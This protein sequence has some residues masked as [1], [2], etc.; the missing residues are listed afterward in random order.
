MKRIILAVLAVLTLLLGA[1]S[2]ASAQTL[3]NAGFAGS[4]PNWLAALARSDAGGAPV[5]LVV[6]GDSISQGLGA[7]VT[8]N[9]YVSQL[10]TTLQSHHLPGG[11]GFQSA[12]QDNSAGTGAYSLTGFGGYVT[13]TGGWNKAMYL[14]GLP[15][16]F[17]LGT[18]G[19]EPHSATWPAV[20]GD[21]LDV[22]YGVNSSEAF[23]VSVDGAAPYVVIA[24]GASC[25]GLSYCNYT[26]PASAGQHS[27]VA[28]NYGTSDFVLLGI[29]GRYGQ[30]V[31]V[32]NMSLYGQTMG[33][34][35]TGFPQQG[36]VTDA[37]Q[38][39]MNPD[40]VIV[41]LGVNDAKTPETDATFT[42]ALT[43][44][45]NAAKAWGP[46]VDVMFVIQAASGYDNT[47]A[48]KYT[49]L[50][51]DMLNFAAAHPGIA[52]D[53]LW[54]LVGRNP[55]Y[56]AEHGLADWVATTDPN[57]SRCNHPGGGL[58]YPNI[59]PNHDGHTWIATPLAQFLG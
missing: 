46:Q 14:S 37:A 39:M 28:S 33:A 20:Q 25:P 51:A 8:S 24:S 22:W 18:T 35:G 2:P 42:A 19:A 59:H 56:Y 58:F 9:G 34:A 57:G 11:T 13:T 15:A 30:G 10:A 4:T 1:P 54:S 31:R 21:N 29:T 44:I 17:A 41:S 55:C 3:P 45:Y 7:G 47:S 48:T 27:V 26:I 36:A 32:H 38:D 6:V 40:L 23:N 52:I 5:N 12:N 50:E 16:G 49:Q 53:D 43:T